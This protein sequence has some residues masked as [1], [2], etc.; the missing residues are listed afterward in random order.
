VAREGVGCIHLNAGQL[1][2]LGGQRGDRSTLATAGGVRPLSQILYD[3]VVGQAKLV[4]EPKM[5]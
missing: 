4:G 5:N 2:G 3:I 1:K